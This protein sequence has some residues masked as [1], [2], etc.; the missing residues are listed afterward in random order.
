[1]KKPLHFG[2]IG[3]NVGYTRSPEIFQAIYDL[4]KVRG[5]FE[6]HSVANG[7]F[8]S[9]MR[10]L[11]LDGV[12]G[13]SITIPHKEKALDC[14]DDLGPVAHAVKAVNSVC[15][16]RGRLYGYN[17]DHYGFAVPLRQYRHLVRSRRVMVLGCGGAARAVLY[18]LYK[19]FDIRRFTLV[20]RTPAR[21]EKLADLC[22]ETFDKSEF[23]VLPQGAQ[24][25][26]RM[27]QCALVVNCTPLGGPNHE[28]ATAIEVS[29][30]HGA[31]KV[32]YDLNYNVNNPTIA[33]FR[34]LGVKTLDGSGMLVGQA[35]RS[36]DLWTGIS[37]EFEPV[38][39]T[40]FGAN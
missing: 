35:L 21:A 39:E 4:L 31:L 3:E 36:F 38:Y 10:Q 34:K 24:S 5:K 26:E 22:A 12:R 16:E 19:D 11:V 28:R 27:H 15:V 40:V 23:E 37:V 33:S 25:V 14:V 8:E 18:A 9:R 7:E 20:N 13:F 1:M 2:L 32:Y 6:V 29:H 30:K 17:T